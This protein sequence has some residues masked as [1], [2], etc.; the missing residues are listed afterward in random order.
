MITN[1]YGASDIKVIFN[2]QTIGIANEL[3]FTVD[4]SISVQSQIDCI[5]PREFVP[6]MYKVSGRVAG[7]LVRS[8]SLEQCGIFSAGGVNL[9][10]PYVSMQI[11]DRRNN[12]TIYTFPSMI[13][14][15]VSITTRSSS[16]VLFD[17]SFNSFGALTD[18]STPLLPSYTG[19]PR[20]DA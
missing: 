5:M 11:L 16:N 2:R 15:D 20:S 7:F 8:T 18:N 1:S 4:Y 10:Q 14:S 19:I 12:Q 9:V 17:F 3:N 13:I 6:G